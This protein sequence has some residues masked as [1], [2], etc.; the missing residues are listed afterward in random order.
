MKHH[1]F[2]CPKLKRPGSQTLFSL[3]LTD[4]SSQPNCANA[5]SV[6]SVLFFFFFFGFVCLKFKRLF[7]L[8][9]CLPV[10]FQSWGQNERSCFNSWTCP[11]EPLCCSVFGTIKITKIMLYVGFSNFTNKL[12]CHPAKAPPVYFVCLS[13]TCTIYVCISNWN[14]LV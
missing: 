1:C 11:S 9:L 10:L 2:S 3:L 4:S 5:G 7:S 14:E 12:S 8:Y 13:I 6:D